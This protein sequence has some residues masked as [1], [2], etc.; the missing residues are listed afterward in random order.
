MNTEYRIEE[1]IESRGLEFSEISQ[2]KLYRK[3]ACKIAQFHS[4]DIENID[5]TPFIDKME[6]RIEK[7]KRLEDQCSEEIFSVEELV[8]IKEVQCLSD[9]EEIEFLKSLV[10]TKNL[11]LSHNDIHGNNVLLTRDNDP[12]LIDYEE[13]CYNFMGFDIGN[14]FCEGM[15]H[16]SHEK[17]PAYQFDE[18]L[19]PSEEELK[20]FLRYYVVF[21]KLKNITS[22]EMLVIL[23]NEEV[24]REYERKMFE[25]GERE[26]L[27]GELLEEIKIGSLVSSYYWT[28]WL[29][30]ISK[31]K[32]SHFDFVQIAKDRFECYKKRK[33]L[34][35]A[36]HNFS[37][38]KIIKN[39]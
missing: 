32:G 26:M 5:K 19:Y 30:I 13:A 3:L 38:A 21:Y 8:F 33:Q 7:W 23:D 6:A 34:I 17:L 12:I 24:L 31:E 39:E 10:P 14:L 28:I 22:E 25:E 16:M 11:V 2:K 18:K 35:L 15:Y 29:V 20:D 1:Y 27:I 36:K 37:T 4:L 9:K